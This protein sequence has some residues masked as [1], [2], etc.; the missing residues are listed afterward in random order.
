MKCYGG[1]MAQVSL[2]NIGHT[3]IWQGEEMTGAVV[4]FS[5]YH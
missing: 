2:L 1:M 3:Q 4:T 5:G